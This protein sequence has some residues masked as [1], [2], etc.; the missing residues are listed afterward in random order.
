MSKFN[1]FFTKLLEFKMVDPV[2]KYVLD[3]IG[4]EL[5]E[6]KD[7][8]LIL[9]SIYFSLR[10]DGNICMSL[11]KDKLLEKWNGKIAATKTLFEDNDNFDTLKFEEFIKSSIEI[12]NNYLDLISEK[13]LPKLIGK[14]KIFVVSG[15]WL[16]LMKYNYSRLEIQSS[17]TR[18]FNKTYPVTYS[19][20]YKDCVLDFELSK[21]QE[22]VIT[23][24]QK[25]NVIVTGGPGT[26]KTTSVLFLLLSLLSINK[27][28]KIYLVAPSG[29]AASRMKESILGGLNIL[30]KKYKED[31]KDLIFI[32]KNLQEYTI[33]R[34][35]EVDSETKTFKYNKN[36]QFEPNSLF[37]IDEASMIDICLFDSL[38]S[39]IPKEARVFIMGDK[40]Q[41]PS[42]ECGAVFGNLLEK[43]ELKYNVIELDE[44]KRFKKDTTIYNLAQAINNQTKLPIVADDFEECKNFKVLDLVTENGKIKE[45]LVSYYKNDDPKFEKENIEYI[46]SKWGER[47]Y[48]DLQNDASNLN[49]F[50]I[51]S[52][53]TLFKKME[54]AKILCAENQSV[55]GIN[56]I[57]RLIV[58]KFIDKTRKTSLENYYAGEI[59]MIVKNNK[60]LD[61][62]NGDCGILVTFAGDDT[63]YFMVEK[64]SKL[65][66]KEGKED[67]E[68]FKLGGY[69]F[70]PLRMISE[71]NF[72]F[73][74]AITVHKSQG[75]DYSQILVILPT[76]K[77]HP[78][79]N[80]QI[81]YTAIT[82]TKGNTYIV[83]SL[84]R[85]EDAK[86]TIVVRDT[87]I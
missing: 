49:P 42:V 83:S 53:K 3:I 56:N 17:L 18:L 12:I 79:L 75:S 35:L 36:K 19:F 66:E 33:H 16:Y 4:D 41:L 85:I 26:G 58:K 20:N 10:V 52:L 87:N 6:N 43:D 74:Y 59:I 86:N 31:N 32:I 61:L 27:E 60:E 50:D 28:F 40:N 64:S 84:E 57:N 62:Y 2:S 71:T 65:V 69:V 15:N 72:D 82:R 14:N 1:E 54:T 70:Y 55:R 51:D 25:R 78:L 22:D 80:K 9:F 21:G 45:N 24:G 48:K 7:E 34:L 47:F 63:L 76:K 29:K 46:V 77:G 11:D 13:N 81:V 5:D 30:S 73:A 39:A 68:I 37:V 67:D 8:L 38:L 44:S 23:I